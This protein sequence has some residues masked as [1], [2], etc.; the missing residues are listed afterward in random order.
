MRPRKSA[1]RPMLGVRWKR[2]QDRRCRRYGHRPDPRTAQRQMG[3]A[4]W[5][6]CTRCGY[7]I[8]PEPRP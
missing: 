2:L 3:G 1:N 5:P 4:L 6:I 8:E 7:A